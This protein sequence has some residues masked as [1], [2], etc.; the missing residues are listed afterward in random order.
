MSKENLNGPTNSQPNIRHIPIHV[1]GRDEPVLSKETESYG[2]QNSTQIPPHQP[3]ISKTSIFDRVKNFPI[4]LDHK[5]GKSPSPSGRTASPAPAAANIPFKQQ[6]QKQN[7]EKDISIQRESSGDDIP[8]PIPPAP[9]EDS[10]IKIQKIQKDVLDLMDKVEQ[11]QGTTRKDKSYI[12]LDEMLTI[13]LLKLDTIDTEGRDNIKHARREAIKC[14]N[15]CISVLENKADTK[16]NST[17]EEIGKT[18]TTKS[19][20]VTG[21]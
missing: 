7:S 6:Y 14:I 15:K 5:L 3:E 12:Y 9:K 13:N 1:E 20:Q 10:I 2:Q 19:T 4:K 16:M 21:V 11:F 17:N 8:P 18:P